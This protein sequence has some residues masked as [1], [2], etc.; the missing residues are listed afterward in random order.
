MEWNT[1]QQRIQQLSSRMHKSFNLY[2]RQYINLCA[3]C[4]YNGG[5]HLEANQWIILEELDEGEGHQRK[6]VCLTKDGRPVSQ[7]REDPAQTEDRRRPRVKH[8]FNDFTNRIFK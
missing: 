1:A 6:V 5:D 2:E 7:G 8:T 3:I 4:T